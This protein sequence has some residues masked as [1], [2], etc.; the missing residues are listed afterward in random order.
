MLEQIASLDNLYLAWTKAKQGKIRRSDVLFF[1]AN[2][3]NNIKN[4]RSEIINHT[5]AVGNYHYFQI[6]EPKIRLICAASFP[7]R[8]LHHALMN[9]CH[10]KFERHLIYDTYATRKYKGIYAA[11]NRAKKFSKQ[12]QFVAKLDVRKYFDSINH[13]IL[14]QH[15][16]KLFRNNRLR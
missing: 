14:K 16:I 10:D 8:V 9:V 15:L 11:L 6:F 4:L 2:L 12:Y 7:E 3:D 1:E 5:L 13:D